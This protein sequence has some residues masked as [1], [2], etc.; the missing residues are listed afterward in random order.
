M[1]HITLH[2]TS[3]IYF[4]TKTQHTKPHTGLIANL[5]KIQFQKKKDNC[6]RIAKDVSQ[7]S[8]THKT[9]LISRAHLNEELFHHQYQQENQQNKDLS[10]TGHTPHVSNRPFSQNSQHPDKKIIEQNKNIKI[11][12]NEEAD[13]DGD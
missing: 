11:S 10:T 3:R 9:N 6:L 4:F 12:D 7:N 1:T 5:K 2:I 8:K 13:D